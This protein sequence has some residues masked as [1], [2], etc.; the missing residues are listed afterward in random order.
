MTYNNIY[1]FFKDDEDLLLYFDPQSKAKDNAEASMEVYHKLLEYSKE[2]GCYFKRCGNIGYIFFKKAPIWEKA[3]GR[4]NVLISFCVKPEFR[5]RYYL[6]YFSKFIKKNLG[7]HFV[8]CLY[9]KNSRALNFLERLGMKKQESNNL[10][11][12]LSI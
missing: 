8:C 6:T 7:S 10:I 4:K 9:T 12:L 5:T 1:E 11:T 2:G 3:F